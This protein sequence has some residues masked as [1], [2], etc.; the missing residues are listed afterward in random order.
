MV[1]DDSHYNSFILTMQNVGSMIGTPIYGSLSDKYGRKITFFI[2]I[3]ITAITAISSVLM[4]DFTAFVI[5]K[6]MNGSLMPSVF[7]QPLIISLEIV[8]PELRTRMNGIVNI[9]WTVGLCVLPLLA[10]F[11]RSWVTLG[12]V[13]SSVTIIFLFYYAFLPES[14]RW[15]V[16]QERYEEAAAILYQIGEKNGKTKEK[17]VLVQKLQKLGERF[18]KE[19]RW[20]KMA[21]LMSYYGLQLNISNLAGNEFIN[22]FLLGIAEV[23]GYL[24]SWIIME[25]F[26]RRWCSVAGFLC[27]GV[28]CMLPAIEFPHNDI[29]SSML[30]KYFAASTFMATYQQSSE[31]YPTVVRSLGMGMSCTVAMLITLVVPYIVYLSIYGKAIPFIIIG[32]FGILAGILASFLPET[33]NENLPQSISDAE[34]FG[35]D[36]K[37]F[38]WNWRRHSIGKE[39]AAS[40]KLSMKAMDTIGEDTVGEAKSKTQVLQNVEFNPSN[41]LN[42]PPPMSRSISDDRQS[43]DF[44]TPESRQNP[45][46]KSDMPMRNQGAENDKE[47]PSNKAP[48]HAGEN[49]KFS[50]ANMVFYNNDGAKT[51]DVV[52]S[53]GNAGIGQAINQRFTKT[54]V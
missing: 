33:L 23:P 11:S 30:G 47:D 20:T 53:D 40:L 43:E 42:A 46:D 15:L 31:L 9:S 22:F 14:P 35:L 39:R 41:P 8:A 26:G 5:I 27:T 3:I 18:K 4:H 50:Y 28:V 16:S 51:E 17:N 19:K 2:T 10:Y 6:T 32:L 12:L 37:F 7:Q 49:L 24:S 1:C 54:D 45:E 36:Q 25:R 52:I 13:A 21:N 29:I 38:S 48:A 44:H 34:N